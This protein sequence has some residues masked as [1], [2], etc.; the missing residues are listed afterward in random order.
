M[1]VP[2]MKQVA[3]YLVVAMFVIGVAPRLDAGMAP[4]EIIAAGQFDRSADLDQVRKVLEMKMVRDRLEKLGYTVDEISTRLDDLSDEQVHQIA[5][6]IDDLR[7]GQ[8]SAVGIII[9][10][11]V[12]IILV[13]VI[14]NLTGRKVVI[15]K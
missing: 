6:H 5:R 7:V 9:G 10:I 8:D 2:F 15:T 4:S 1:R 3:W 12:V 13:I 11:L 14:L